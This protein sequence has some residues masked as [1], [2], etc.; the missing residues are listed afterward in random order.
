MIDQVI[1]MATSPSRRMEALTRTRPKAMLPILGRPMIA[2][3]MEGYYKAGIRRYIVVVG[4]QEGGVVEWLTGKWHRDVKL[5]FVLRGHR[6]GTA[7]ALFAARSL[8]SGPFIVTGCDNLVSEGHIAHLAHYFDSHPGDEAL[9]SLFHA[10]DEIGSM[11]GVLL[12]P[13]EH[14][15]YIS[16]QATEVYQ[17]FMTVLPIY[18]F[19]SKVLDYL[20]RV[21]VVEERGERMLTSAIQMMIDDG[22]VVGAILADKRIRLDTPDDLL[23]ANMHLMTRSASPN[24]SGETAASVQVI[25]PVYVDPG[26]VIGSGSTIGPNVYLETGTVLGANVH[27]RDVVVLGRRIGARQRIENQ[28]VYKDFPPLA[29]G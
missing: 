9:L 26:V 4:E 10:P 22:L 2:H 17:D 16:E 19:R 20:D 3:V 28:V 14:V 25:P 6:R 18:S 23:R 8:I 12:N 13:R 5:N 11:P 15:I 24:L 27:L 21:P 1:V 7:S 29:S